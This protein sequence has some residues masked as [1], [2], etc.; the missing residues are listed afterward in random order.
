MREGVAIGTISLRRTEAHLFTERQVALLQTLADPAVI[1]IENTRLFEE[2][3]ARTRELTR[4]LDEV[5][6]LGEVGRIVSTLELDK[7]LSTIL[8]RHG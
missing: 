1:A 8:K 4:S 2:V 5:R 7:V 3:Q 6:A